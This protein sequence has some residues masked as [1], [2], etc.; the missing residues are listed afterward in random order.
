MTEKEILHKLTKDSEYYGDFGKQFLSASNIR[1]L[2]YSPTNFNKTEKTLPLLEGR[3]FHTA[4]LEPEK[5]DDIPIITCNS[6]NTKEFRSFCAENELSSYDVLLRKEK[7]HLDLMIEKL[8]SNIEVFDMIYGKDTEYEVPNITQIDNVM[9]KGKCDIITPDNVFDLKTSSNVHKFRY[10]C[11]EYCYDSQAYIY[12]KLFNK[13]MTFIVIDK[14]TFEIK[15]AECSPEFIQNGEMK[16]KNA[17][18]VYKKF[19]KDDSIHNINTYIYK[20]TL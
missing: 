4:I 1:D 8:L 16:V 11:K 9:F 6:R 17:I 18:K 2:L 7:E 10:S 20:E 5:K 12:Q 14:K 13:P 3:Y 15:I 19:F